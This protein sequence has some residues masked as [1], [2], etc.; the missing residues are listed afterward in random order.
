MSKSMFTDGYASMLAILIKLRKDSSI[1]QVAL[2]KKLGKAQPFVS[3]VERGVRR[4]DLIEFCAI[5]MALG[6]D[7]EEVF[8][9]VIRALPKKVRI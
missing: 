7:P 3:N 6:A 4:I 8:R 9:M 1:T 2:S 5:V